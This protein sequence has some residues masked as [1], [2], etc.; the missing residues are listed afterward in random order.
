MK[1]DLLKVSIR[2]NA[3]YVPVELITGNNKSINGTTSVVVANASKLG[4]TFS[5]ELLH[6][7][8]N[9]N[10]KYK[11]ELLDALKE[12]TGVNKN[13]TPLAKEWNIPTGETVLE[14]VIT[15]FGN[16]FQTKKGTRLNCGHII[17]HDTFP[18]ERYNGCPFCGT[19]FE[20]GE[21]EYEN[22]GSKLKVL[23][24]WKDDDVKQ[25]YKDLLKS[26][27]ALDATQVD[28]L[29][30]LLSEFDLPQ[31]LEI[32]IKE[33]LMLV[34]DI[35]VENNRS[36]EAQILFNNPNDILRYLW[37]KHTGFLQIIEPKTIINRVSKNHRN[38]ISPLDKNGV[39][40]LQ[41]KANLKLKYSRQDC[42]RV[43][44]WLNNLDLS[45]E[46]CCEIMHPKRGMWVRFIRALRLAEYGKRKGFEKVS[47]L[48]DVF[49]NEDYE[50]WQSKVNHF[51]LKSDAQNTFKLLRQRPG[52]FARSLFS[53]MLW[54]GEDETLKHFSEITD[55]I[56]A[57]LVFTLSMYAQT[58]FDKNATRNV[59]PL[60]GTNKRV[61]ANKFLK[62]YQDSHL[63][64][65]QSKIEDL[66]LEVMRKRFANMENQNKTI[67][68]D[69]GLFNI[70]V[71]IGDRGESVQDLPSALMGTRFPVEGNTVRLFLQW[72]QGLPAQHLD[73]DLSCKVAYEHKTDFCSY[74]QLVVA[75][76][77]HSG[78]IQRIPH[79]IG[80]AEY[81]DVNLD[82]LGERGAK[83]VSFTCNAY[84]NGSLSPNL[85]VGWMDSK[86]PMR[87]SRK[88]GVAYDP[89]CVQHQVRITQKMTKGLVFGVLDVKNREIVWLEMAF[90]GQLVQNL[91]T[92]AVEALLNKLNS[93]LNIGNLLR[94]K[95]EAQ[96]LEIV[97][98]AE[99][100]DESYD[101]KWAANAAKVTQLL[102]D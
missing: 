53:N 37:Y 100:A 34:I 90:G 26:K 38:I 102:I 24:L 35:L 101:L 2:Q 13:W 54:F 92:K 95:A 86:H 36:D 5:E 96:G 20:F 6:V 33:T 89:T 7:L 61:A 93:K 19:P 56:P 42:K 10:P 28:S 75:G 71:A 74:S 9:V 17:P 97:S 14:H 3:V 23:E 62:L 80:T 78:D 98:D 51:R 1:Q 47:K 48:L 21:I 83:Y 27:T 72:G 15:L 99:N 60:G 82:E 88:T 91:D 18:L 70:P 87:I 57:R 29:K 45:A 77:K 59:K 73:M 25:F 40:R 63:K 4:F 79:M 81:I 8:N 11:L 39:A 12:I 94:L 32:G 44:I 84:S 76:C 41:S 69:E 52:L 68:I 58:Y 22:Q 31:D 67:Y 66:C 65:M 43:A 30:M 49:Y 55:K 46:K 50:V 64:Q 16:I 85:V